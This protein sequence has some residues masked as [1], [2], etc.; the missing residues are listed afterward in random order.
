MQDAVREAIA[1]LEEPALV[2]E[3]RMPEDALLGGLVGDVGGAR[4]GSANGGGIYMG[5]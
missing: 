1:V 5:R 3:P 4:A 2:G